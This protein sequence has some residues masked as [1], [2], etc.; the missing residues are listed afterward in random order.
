MGGACIE[1]NYIR[2]IFVD[3]QWQCKGIGTYLLN[4]VKHGNI[5]LY[6]HVYVRNLEAINWY[7]KRGFIIK[8]IHE[9]E[10]GD[11]KQLKYKM[12]WSR[13]LV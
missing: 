7:F 1:V 3:C 5:F 9:P 8:N 13:Q 11:P 6:L 12:I 4:F 10:T 2:E